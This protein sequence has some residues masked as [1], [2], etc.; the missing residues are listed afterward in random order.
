MAAQLAADR[1]W[2]LREISDLKTA[3]LRADE[4]LQQ[5]LLR[6]LVAISYAHWEGSVRFSARK[7]LEHVALRKFP[8]DKLNRQFLR[9]KF[10]PR[11]ASLS[12]TKI[13]V[14]D[15]CTIIDDILS[16]SGRFSKSNPDLISTKSNLN[17]DVFRDIC[18][19]CAIPPNLFEDKTT[20]IDVVL[21]KRRNA[22]AHGEETFISVGDL[23]ALVDETMG[24][25]RA[26]ADALENQASLKSYRA[27]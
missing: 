7:Y 21:L 16:D 13:S 6:S 11:L 20:F 10:L 17:S 23:D 8:Y 12:G 4:G 9:N 15:R 14:S 3:I 25:M 1:T 18:I 5:V 2:R 19:V 24:L 26:F 27:A 22:I